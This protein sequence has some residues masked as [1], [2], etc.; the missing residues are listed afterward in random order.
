M[1]SYTRYRKFVIDPCIA[2]VIQLIAENKKVYISKRY[3][4]QFVSSAAAALWKQSLK[5]YWYDRFGALAKEAIT[6]VKKNMKEEIDNL[7]TQI[8]ELEH[9]WVP[10]LTNTIGNGL[11][12]V[13]IPLVKKFEQGNSRISLKGLY[14]L[15]RTNI[16]LKDEDSFL[17]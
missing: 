16:Q 3:K 9:R 4:L 8:I 17:E 2:S 15:D 7:V 10:Q 11:A 6:K 5:T 14:D 12:D 1:S 13:L